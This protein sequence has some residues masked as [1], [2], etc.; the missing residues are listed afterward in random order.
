MLYLLGLKQ[1]PSHRKVQSFYWA[2]FAE[3]FE[4]VLG[5]CRSEPACR[6]FERRDANLIEL[7]QDYEREDQ[8]LLQYLQEFFHG[9]VLQRVESLLDAAE[10]ISHMDAVISS[11][12][13]TSFGTYMKSMSAPFPSGSRCLFKRYASLILL[14]MRFLFTALLKDFLLTDTMIRQ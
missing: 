8:D 4:G 1:D 5:T 7:Y 10:R 11:E 9:A 2:V 12:Q 3:R 13:M 6:R 14:L